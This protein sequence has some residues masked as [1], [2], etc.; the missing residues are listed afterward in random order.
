MSY[1]GVLY[2]SLSEEVPKR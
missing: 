1:E 2:H